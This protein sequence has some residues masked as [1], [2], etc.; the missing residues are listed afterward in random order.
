MS[1]IRFKVNFEDK[2]YT[3]ENTPT[4][5]ENVNYIV[6]P[7]AESEVIVYA[8]SFIKQNG[9]YIEQLKQI[10]KIAYVSDNLKDMYLEE[11]YEDMN[12]EYK[13]DTLDWVTFDE[14]FWDIYFHDDPYEAA[15]AVYFGNIQSWDDNYIR[16]NGYNNL[17]TT[18]EI[19]YETYNSEI[20]ENWIW[21][22]LNN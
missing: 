11:I 17:E 4:N 13:P 3:L 16:F 12:D 22:K 5:I 21:D 15:R 19:D 18:N 7:I 9:S 20:I 10:E 14:E 6:F 8:P 2:E 1:N